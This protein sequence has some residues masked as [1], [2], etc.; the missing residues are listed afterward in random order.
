MSFEFMMFHHAAIWLR[1]ALFQESRKRRHLRFSR[2]CCFRQVWGFLK[3]A[4]IGDD[5]QS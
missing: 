5:R 3:L 1:L 4:W 2:G